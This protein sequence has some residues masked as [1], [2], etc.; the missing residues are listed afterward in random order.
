MRKWLFIILAAAFTVLTQPAVAHA[1]QSS[2]RVVAVQGTVRVRARADAHQARLNEVVPVG[3]AVT[4]GADSSAELSNGLQHVTMSANSRMIISANESSGV[5]RIVQSLGSILFQVD[6]RESPHF[7]VETPRLAAIVK[8]TTFSVI[9]LPRWDVVAVSNG[10]VEVQSRRGHSSVDVATGEAARVSGDAPDEAVLYSDPSL[11]LSAT[12][13]AGG[14]ALQLRAGNVVTQRTLDQTAASVRSQLSSATAGHIKFKSRDN[15]LLL[16][17]LFAYL[18]VSFLVGFGAFL[19]FKKF[20][21]MSRR[22]N[23]RGA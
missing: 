22:R 16:K 13:A 11:A 19:G 23:E 9:V 20:E 21:E 18:G 10:L 5:T 7:Y 4:T 3:S 15:E 6:H 14:G 8:G 2:W 17:A 12:P 1:Q